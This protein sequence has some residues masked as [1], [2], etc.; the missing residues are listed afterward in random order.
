MD[1]E[2]AGKIV[3]CLF[4]LGVILVKLALVVVLLWVAWHFISKYW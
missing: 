2:D 1:A 3:G 4:V